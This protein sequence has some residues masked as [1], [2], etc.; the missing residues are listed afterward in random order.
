[1]SEFVTV[2]G[3][4]N[5]DIA[6]NMTATYVEADSIPGH[7]SMSCGGVARNV[8]HN[9]R[10]MDDPVKFISLFGGDV[11]GEMCQREC[12]A[13]GLDLSLSQRLEGERNGLYLCVNDMFGEMRAAVADNE[14]IDHLTPAFLE[15][16]LNT[17]NASAAVVADTNISI[18]ALQYL[19]E[20]CPAALFVDSVSTTKAP[21]VITALQQSATHRLHCLKLN[22]KEALTVTRCNNVQEAAA[23]LISMGVEQVFITLGAEGVYC[24]NGSC[25]EHLPAIPTR[26]VNTTGAGD[27][28]MAGVVHAHLHHIPFPEVAQVGL[29]TARAALLSLQTVN[30]DIIKYL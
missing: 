25:H 9:L 1:M 26:V 30:P 27:A 21:R 16:R 7:V 11:F 8:A 4:V 2:I 13:I 6:A 3:G 22:L 14:I 10:L 18:E 17:I 15:Q 24:S 5:L 29:K 12:E 20:L 28:F 23:Q 19:I